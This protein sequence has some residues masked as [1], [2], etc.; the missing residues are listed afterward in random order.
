LDNRYYDSVIKEMQPFFDEQGFKLSDGV[1]KNDKKAVKVEY[2]DERQMYVLLIA[3]VAED[4]NIGEFVE[5]NAWLFD[6]SQTERDTVSVGI[7]F[8]D[9]L[10]KNMGVKVKAVNRSI[11][12]PTAEK[13]DTLTI[14]GF[15]KKVL[16][17]YP[18]FKEPYKD[19]IAKYGNFL[20]MDFF[21]ETFIPQIKVTLKENNKKS[22]KKLLDIIENAYLQGDRDT[23]NV[24]VFCL[25]AAAQD[26]AEQKAAVL[27]LV[28]G[29]THLK[30]S[31]ENLIPF[32]ASKKKLRNILIK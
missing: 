11:D 7:D 10:R 17:I 1:Y 16:D 20:Y 6:D 26:G 27:S 21:A 25:A 24:A 8:T 22:L 32:V 29:N 12:L 19:H 30:S 3:D 5:A 31:V 2:S 23:V 14:S 15:A 28:E 4:G 18:Q 13:G 9:T